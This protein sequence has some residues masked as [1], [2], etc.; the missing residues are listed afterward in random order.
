MPKRMNDRLGYLVSL[1]VVRPDHWENGHKR[2]N[3]IFALQIKCYLDQVRF[4]LN[5]FIRHALLIPGKPPPQTK[6]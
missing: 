1:A 4:F 5:V 6:T 3:R 2:P